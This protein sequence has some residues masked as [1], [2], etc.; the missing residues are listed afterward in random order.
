MNKTSTAVEL[1]FD[2]RGSPSLS[3]AVK[4]RLEGLAGSRLTQEGG[5]DPVLAGL[6]LAGDEPPRGARA[7]LRPDPPGRSCEL[8]FHSEQAPNREIITGCQRKLLS[9]RILNQIRSATARPPI[10]RPKAD[11]PNGRSVR[12]RQ[13][14]LSNNLKMEYAGNS[15]VRDK[16]RHSLPYRYLTHHDDYGCNKQDGGLC[17]LDPEGAVRGRDDIEGNDRKHSGVESS[18]GAGK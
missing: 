16:P 6:A 8:I 4:A 3:E 5:A 7:P 9:P 11:R 14:P 13:N 1:R 2:V 15:G 10:P 18:K 12:L 17:G